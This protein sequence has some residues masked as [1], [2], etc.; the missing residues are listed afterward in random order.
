MIENLLLLDDPVSAEIDVQKASCT[1]ALDDIEARDVPAAVTA[2]P[3][4]GT[5]NAS[6][7]DAR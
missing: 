5:G 1:G 2:E 6:R 3:L 7:G 4:S